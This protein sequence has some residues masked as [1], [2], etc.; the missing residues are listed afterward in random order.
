MTDPAGRL[1]GLRRLNFEYFESLD[2][3]IRDRLGMW[4]M[5]TAGLDA[6][7]ANHARVFKDGVL[8]G[9]YMNIEVV[10]KEFLEDHF[11]PDD[12]EGNLWE[13]GLELET[14]EA[15]KDDT[16]LRALSK[17]VSAEPDEGDHT[18]FYAGLDE[19]MDIKQVLRVMATETALLSNDNFSNGGKNFYYYE[20]PKRGFM[21]LPW[22]LDAI[23]TDPTDSDA[24]AYWATHSRFKLR[25]LINQ[26]PEWRE[27]FV[28]DVVDVRDNILPRLPAEVDRICNQIRDY[29]R[30]DP[31][32][33]KTAEAADSDCNTVKLRIGLRSTALKSQLGR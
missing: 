6:S 14:N 15:V 4:A 25:T 27:Q 7:R 33:A 30:Q 16:R 12:E 22:D 21:V 18:A 17:L 28:T 26:N 32:R 31:N 10:D 5:R 23:Y 29:V 1:R 19:L 13:E 11:G 3:P 24:F 9:L 2:A 20:H 8:L